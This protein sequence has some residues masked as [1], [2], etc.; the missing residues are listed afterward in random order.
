MSHRLPPLNGLRAFEAA[1]RHLSFKRAA[2][3]LS[4][5]PGAVSQQV[6]A[7]ERSM[8]VALFRR[9]HRALVLTPSGEALVPPLTSAFHT[10]SKAMETVA[11]ALKGRRLRLGVARKLMSSGGP[12]IDW[13][14]TAKAKAL[15]DIRTSDDV[16]ALMAGK[17]DALLRP[18]GG[19]YPGFHSVRFE[20]A[21]ATGGSAS[22]DLVSV[23]GLAGCREHEAVARALY[24]A[25]SG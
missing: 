9:L 13:L 17:L 15:V 14:A 21:T 23:P 12:A 16:A 22:A 18:A 24:R 8:G 7:L 20:L 19:T 1:A 6:K 25:R 4:V 11:P 5:T 3:E 10:I 2:D